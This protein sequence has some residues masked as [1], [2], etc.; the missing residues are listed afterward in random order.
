MPAAANSPNNSEFVYNSHEKKSVTARWSGLFPF[1]AP[2]DLLF[3]A[4]QIYSL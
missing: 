1:T 4:K 2:E 3:R